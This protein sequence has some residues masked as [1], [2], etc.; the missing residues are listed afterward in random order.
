[1]IQSA[2]GKNPAEPA[3]LVV[4][5]EQEFYSYIEDRLMDGGFELLETSLGMGWSQCLSAQAYE[6]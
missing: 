5:N 3:Y 4:K 6:G 2:A 1:M